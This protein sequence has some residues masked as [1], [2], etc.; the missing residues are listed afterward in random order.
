MAS[1]AETSGKSFHW[2]V[3]LFKYNEWWGLVHS[4]CSEI[5]S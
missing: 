5:L 4:L 1:L 2:N 3:T